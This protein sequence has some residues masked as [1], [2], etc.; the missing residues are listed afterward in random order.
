MPSL[1]VTNP[2]SLEYLRQR[3]HNGD[4]A[5]TDFQRD[6]V[7][8]PKATEELIESFCRWHHRRRLT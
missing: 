7:W 5:L 6:F 8:E 1:F 2:V 3:I 4:P